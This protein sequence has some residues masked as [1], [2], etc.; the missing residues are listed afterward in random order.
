MKIV[1]AQFYTNNVPYGKY[2]EE[3]NRKYCEEKGYEY[4]CEKDTL[5]IRTAIENRAPT[6]YKP[7]LI[8]EVLDIYSPEYVLFLDIDAII[9]DPTQV[10][11]SFIDP[12]YDL[13][14]AEDIGD[15]SVG[16]AGVL[17]LK[18]SDWTKTFLS[19]WWESAEIYKG[20][21]S[22]NLIILEQNLNKAGYFKQALWHDQT[23]LTTLYDSN[24]DYK[25][26]VKVISNR[27]FNYREYNQENFIFHAFTYGALP[28]RK[29]DIIHREIM[30]TES[31]LPEINLIVYHVYCVGNYV[32]VVKKQL[33]RLQKSGAYDWCDKLEITCINVDNDFEAVEELLKDL[34]KTNLTKFKENEFE[35]RGIK[36]VWDYSQEYKGKV[37]YFHTKGVSNRY[38]NLETKQE[39]EWKIRGVEWWK[40]IMEYFL[41]DNFK[42]CIQELELYDQCGVTSVNKWWWGNFWWS[43]LEWIQINEEPKPGTRWLFESWLNN[44]R[45]PSYREFYHF[46]FNP[47]YTILPNDI[48]TNRNFYKDATLEV[49]S[50]FYGILGEQQDEGRPIIER[51]V[52]DVTNVIKQNLASNNYRGFNIG[53]NNGLGGDPYYGVTKMLEVR[54]LIN[55]TEYVIVVDENRQ[56]S[57]YI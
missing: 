33:D 18:N 41:I 30:K 38:I 24:K 51:T 12:N 3:I 46:E 6:W 52:I 16:N 37:L 40:E 36:K 47:Y 55:S 5:K 11:E 17:L 19:A 50:A 1:V 54:F 8:K 29:L 35:Y 15:H 34:P 44:L 7:K 10:I 42:D 31:T 25:E 49:V 28:N 56:L 21:D 45:N 9:S 43:K 53:V 32:E 48:Y 23:C 39:S 27:S 57:F 13:I 2:A 26:H 20:K 4:Y 14:L 22:R